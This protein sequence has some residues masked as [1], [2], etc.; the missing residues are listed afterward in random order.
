MNTRSFAR[1]ASFVAAS[2]VSAVAA[3]AA[4]PAPDKQDEI[5]FDL[6][7]NAAFVD[8]MR[9]SY[10]VEPRAHATVIRGKVNDTL[11]LDLYGFKP[12]LQFD[13]FTIQ[14]SPFFDDG[15]KDPAF[16]GSFG[17]AWY[18]SD[19][20]VNKHGSSRTQIRTILL[21]QIFGFDA[22]VGLNPVNTF[23]VGFWFNN[24][25]DAQPCS[26]TP[27]KPTPFNGEHKAGPFA[28]IS[29]TS[30]QTTLGPLCTAPTEGTTPVACDP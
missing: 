13:L 29:A 19:V 7:P 28:M 10:D 9:A 16:T 11:V 22:D 25:D 23:H 18:Q 5:S 6:V 21:D 26:A 8:C 14:H 4:Q 27:I 3:V 30:R 15:A 24:P 20:E 1:K 2:L 17:M 12:G